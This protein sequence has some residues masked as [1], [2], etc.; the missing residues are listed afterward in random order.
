VLRCIMVLM[1]FLFRW[2]PAAAVAIGIFWLSHQSRPPGAG[3]AP[4]YVGHFVA[5]SVFAFAVVWGVTNCLR[6]VSVGRMV[7]S[8]VLVA[9]YAVSDEYHQSFTPGRHPSSAD[10]FVDI[11][12]ASMVVG[13]IGWVIGR[14]KSDEKRRYDWPPRP[15]RPPETEW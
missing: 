2:A 12:A 9:L 15:M 6:E 10:V 8:W 4:D 5:Y 1:T 13:L 3:L 7:L 14:R 11:L